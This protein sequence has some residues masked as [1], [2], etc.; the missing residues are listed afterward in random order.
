MKAFSFRVFVLVCSLIA[1]A[2]PL[3]PADLVL[4]WKDNSDNEA[5]FAVERRSVPDGPFVE[6]V[7]TPANVVSWTDT[8]LPPGK[9]FTYRL[10][11]FNSA[12]FSGYT[13]EVTATTGPNPPAVP[14]DLS[15]V[16]P[17]SIV[18]NV[19]VPK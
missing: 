14:S 9:P 15:V 10:R 11:A 4:S 5:G 2:R 17:V 18:I 7:R 12:G 19:T 1:T 3:F 16:V 8:G 13:P 6:V